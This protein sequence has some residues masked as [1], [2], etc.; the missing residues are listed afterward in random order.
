M[1]RSDLLSQLNAYQ[2]MDAEDEHSR[3]RIES[4][5]RRQPHCFG[6]Q[7][8]IGHVTGSAWII[9]LDRD[10]ALLT[11]HRKLN[12]W[13]QLGGHSDGDSNTRAVALREGVEESGLS[14]LRLLGDEI[15]DVD[16]HTIPARGAEPAHEHYDVRYLLE[17]DAT[18]PLVVSA[19]SHHLAWVPL[20]EIAAMGVDNSVL[21]MVA[22]TD[23]R[24]G[25]LC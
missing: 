17:A 5:V 11:H 2:P 1:H 7:L 22:K 6:R 13:L 25:G 8:S 14:G 23:R 18:W 15:F 24:F 21:R 9:D 4:F 12:L 16:V 19:E 20:A 3:R 10:K